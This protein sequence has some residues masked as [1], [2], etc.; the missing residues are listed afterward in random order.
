MKRLL[1]LAAL[2]LL[3]ACGDLATVPDDAGPLLG[4]DAVQAPN[5]VDAT[6][7][8]LA[9][10]GS[11]YRIAYVELITTRPDLASP[12]VIIASDVGNKRLAFDFIPGDP[13]RGG[14]DGDPNTIDTWVDL[15]DG[16]ATG[17]MDAVA[18][19]EAIG[20]A[21]ATWDGETCSELGMSLNPV[22]VDLGLV[23][24]ILGYGGGPAVPDVMHA[25]WLPGDFFDDIVEDG[26]TFVLGATFTLTFTSGD[27]DMDGN[28][29]L[30]ARE[31]YYNNAFGWTDNG[32]PGLIDV[33]TIALHE[34]GH[35]LS[36][37]H[38]GKVF[39]N[40]RTEE[41]VFSPRAVMNA[42]Y[43]GPNRAL[44]GTDRSGHCGLWAGWP[45]N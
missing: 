41:V 27:L 29:D 25:G 42:V 40:S 14:A 17:G 43:S 28:P 32:T 38:F 26:S 24:N 44:D 7:A 45:Q 36:Q 13:R 35:A 8:L 39:F 18:T 16:A 34:A 1:V 12:N 21:M 31:I 23:Q 6:N 37:A 10:A 30:A 11:E 33:E 15:V 5:M 22:P 20:G 19:T 9:A 3:P 2:G 4:T